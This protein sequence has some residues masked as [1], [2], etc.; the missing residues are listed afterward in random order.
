MDVPRVGDKLQIG[1]NSYALKECVTYPNGGASSYYVHDG[2]VLILDENICDCPDGEIFDYSLIT[3]KQNEYMHAYRKVFR[4]L[5]GGAEQTADAS[6]I[7][8]ANQSTLQPSVPSHRRSIGQIGDSVTDLPP[9]YPELPQS[10]IARIEAILADQ[11]YH[12]PVQSGSAISPDIDGA[13]TTSIA[14]NCAGASPFFAD[15]ADNAD[16]SPLEWLFEQNFVD[17]YGMGSLAFLQKEYA[18]EDALGHRFFLDYVVETR[19]GFIAVE[20]NGIQYHH[21]QIIG[22]E[23]YRAQL[24]KQNT[25]TQW[26]IRLYRFS[27]NDCRYND[28][29]KDDIRSF[30]GPDTN[31]FIPGGLVAERRVALYEHQKDTLADIAEKRKEGCRA[32]LIV[33]PT[34]SGK[35]RIVEE[36]MVR[37]AAQDPDFYALIMA[38][39]GNILEDWHRRIHGAMPALERRV[40][41]RSYQYMMRHYQELDP[42]TYTYEVCDEAHHAVAPVIR[43][44]VQYFTPKSL[45]GLTATDQRPDRKR[46]ESIFGSYNTRLSLTDAMQQKI[47][48]EAR[49]FRIETNLDLSRVRINGRDYVNADLERNICVT[50]R[51]DLIGDVLR[52]YFTAGGAGNLQGI[53]FCVNTKHTKEMEKVLNARGISARAYSSREKHPERIMEDFRNHKFRF[54]CACSMISEGWDYPE[55]GILVMARP[56]LS[57]VL[58]LQQ[59]GRGLRRTRIKKEVFVLDVVDEYGPMAKAVNMHVIFHNPYYVPLGFITRQNYRVGD[60]IEVNGLVERVEQ[61]LPVDIDSFEERYGNYLNQEQVAR[62]FFLSTGSVTKW[63]RDGRITPD[64]EIPFGSHRIFL[65]TREHVEEIRQKLGIP[66]HNDATIRQDFFDFLEERDYSLSYKMPFLLAFFDHVNSVGDAGIDEILQDYI[67]FYRNRI[68]RGLPV[69]RPT[70]PYNSDRLT[71]A[72]FMKNSMLTNPFEKFERKRFLYYSRDLGFI[73][74]NHALF[75][76]LSSEDITRIRDQMHADLRKYYEKMGGV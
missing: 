71:G 12:I 45:V 16:A 42:Q 18:I 5:I 26:G 25:C 62:E 11:T 63:I 4:F 30:F 66:V 60:M 22:P 20:E 56:T 9:T 33:L 38:P 23:R 2:T 57:R 67:A 21:P 69:D 35:S 68:A 36:D 37:C 75:T 51:N 19:H 14:G 40:E 44:V 76:Q 55:L 59:V 32:F 50:S 10:E 6:S 61:I 31:D 39:N 49:V 46:L 27:T 47:I 70:C 1:Q 13:G 24:H 8:S 3:D 41:I 34:A 74:M 58:Y 43:R 72:K 17:V 54:L 48:A 28:R 15:R 52:Q 65:F 7:S 73:S 29:I 53:V 64:V